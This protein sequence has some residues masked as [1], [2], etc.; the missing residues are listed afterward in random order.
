MSKAMDLFRQVDELGTDDDQDD[1]ESA[2]DS[3]NSKQKERIN[4]IMVND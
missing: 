4:T 3:K 1:N 2:K